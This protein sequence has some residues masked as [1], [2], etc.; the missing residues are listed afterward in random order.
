M[1]TKPIRVTREEALS[2]TC[3]ECGA[4]PDTRCVSTESRRA[5]RPRKRVHLSRMGA[6][7]SLLLQQAR[8]EQLDRE[9]AESP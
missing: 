7:R 1:P 3:P 9:R 5:G 8:E 6:Y 2:L 4:E